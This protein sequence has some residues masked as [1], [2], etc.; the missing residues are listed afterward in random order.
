LNAYF[1]R[2]SQKEVIIKSEKEEK[3]IHFYIW[4]ISKKNPELSGLV[5]YLLVIN[6]VSLKF[7]PDKNKNMYKT[8]SY[9]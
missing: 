9:L 7:I 8:I 2:T 1:P 3:A 5:I 6:F 4:L